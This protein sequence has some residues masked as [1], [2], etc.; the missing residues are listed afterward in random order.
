VSVAD[1]DEELDRLYG[2]PLDEFTPARNELAKSLKKKGDDQPAAA[3]KSLK[4]PSVSAGVV[5]QLARR[6]PKLMQRLLT[7]GVELRQA[8]ERVLRGGGA[9]ELRRASDAERDAVRA[10]V[11]AARGLH[12]SQPVL[13]RV[14]ESLRA[15]AASDEETRT[16]LERGRLTA[17]VE[18]AGFPAIVAAPTD[19][20][21]DR[22]R[23]RRDESAQRIRGLRARLR[24]L[25]REEARAQE[26]ARRAEEQA[27]R[28]RETAERA[29]EARVEA[30]RAANELS[31]EVERT[32]AEL[33]EAEG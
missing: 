25:E 26:A 14:E 9:E 33:A 13:D 17:D 22:R 1:L 31:A 15:A 6:E 8:Q 10:L 18:R 30:E 4:K 27:A 29:E 12:V 20:L 24:T 3:V 2:L 5:N 23:Q 16:A 7:A 28:A 32:Q 11:H 19:E 21:A